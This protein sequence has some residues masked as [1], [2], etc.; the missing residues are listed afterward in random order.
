MTGA[1]YHQE[2]LVQNVTFANN[3]LGQNNMTLNTTYRLL[4][5]NIP[6]NFTDGTNVSA[7]WWMYI[8][9]TVVPDTYQNHIVVVANQ[10]A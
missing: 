10:S 3:S 1:S 7:Y 2:I 9:Q 6:V 8:P 4:K 5:G